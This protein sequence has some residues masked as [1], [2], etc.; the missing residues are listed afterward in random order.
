[1]SALAAAAAARATVRNAVAVVTKRRCIGPAFYCLRPA[2]VCIN[3]EETKAEH[4]WA[5]VGLLLLTIVAK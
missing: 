3:D 4:F 2:A 5:P 1:L